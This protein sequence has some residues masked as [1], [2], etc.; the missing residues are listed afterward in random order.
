MTRRR[1]LLPDLAVQ[2]W[3]DEEAFAALYAIPKSRNTDHTKR[4][5][6]VILLAAA[7][8]AGEKW[9]TVWADERA[10]SDNTWYSTWQFIPE[11]AVALDICTQKAQEA[12][13]QEMARFE[14]IKL[15]QRLKVTAEGAVDAVQGL[16]ITALSRDDRADHRNEASRLLLTIA[17]DVLAARLGKAGA[18]VGYDPPSAGMPL[19]D[20]GEAEL[21]ALIRNLIAATGFTGA[22][23]TE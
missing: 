8:A 1:K 15:R 11:I 6:T 10:C 21:D 3:L 19:E 9:T 14:T 20:I 16:R 12:A 7:T 17:D 18:R 22:P 5:N 13:A 2:P 4:I 23:A